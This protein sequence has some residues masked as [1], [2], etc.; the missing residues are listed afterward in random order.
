MS[1]LI[2]DD[3]VDDFSEHDDHEDDE[4][5][6]EPKKI[7]IKK[8]KAKRE[9]KSCHFCGNNYWAIRKKGDL[10]HYQNLYPK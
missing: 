9:M 2:D 1:N 6:K 8:K 3:G 4:D 5:F 10:N 7:F